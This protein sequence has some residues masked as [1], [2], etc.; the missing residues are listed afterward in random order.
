M[1]RRIGIRREDKNKWERRVPVVPADLEDLVRRCGLSFT[2]QPSPVRTFPDPAFAE[3]G[4]EV[5]ESLDDC[6]VVLAVKEIPADLFRENTAYLFFSHTV[7]GQPHNMDM[8]RRLMSK[9]CHL[10]DYERIM[11]HSGET[12]GRRL[13]FF[14]R[15]AG[16]AGMIDTLWGVGRRWASEGVAPNPFR[17]VRRACEY[18][19]L[20]EAFAHLG[21][22]GEGI[23]TEGFSEKIGP[24]VTGFAGYGNVSRGAQEILDLFPVVPV[25]PEDLAG[26]TQGSWSRRTVYKAVF[27]ERHMAAPIN[28]GD[29]GAAEAGFDL[30]RY[31][32]HPEEF[33]GIFDRWL[34]WLTVL[35]NCIYWDTPYPRIVTRRSLDELFSETAP[36][37]VA[38]G[39]ISC[40]I[41]GGVEVTVKATEPDSPVY[42]HEPETGRIKDGPLGSGPLI[43]AVDNLPCEFPKESS[44]DFSRALSLFLPAIAAADYSVP[45]ADLALP[46]EI[47]NAMIVYQGELTP[48]YGFMKNFL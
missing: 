10:I 7:K 14:G 11:G 29:T 23:R 21:E 40:D 9:S 28:A 47:K 15:Y 1:M 45:F 5:S 12:A 33:R 34:P 17:D 19:D 20:E 31:Y 22:I 4:A 42:V 37:L 35:M 13:I 38:I 2:V 6:G 24:F 27:E 43:M 26:L 39:D 41:R 18:T 8:L 46:P 25:A 30:D 32:R 36:R 3:A 16:L 44:T 48:G